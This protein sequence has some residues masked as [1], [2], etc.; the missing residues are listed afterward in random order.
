MSPYVHSDISP[1][2]DKVKLVEIYEK[3]FGKNKTDGFFIEAGAFNGWNWSPTSP[4]ALIGWSGVFVEPQPDLFEACCKRWESNKDKIHVIK[5]CVGN[6]DGICKLYLNGS[7]STTK[8][9]VMGI[10]N[11]LAL[12]REGWSGQLS[13][14]NFIESTMITLDLLINMFSVPS[15]FDILVID[16]EGAEKDVLDGLTLEEYKPKIMIIETH[17]KFDVK[18]LSAKASV[19]SRHLTKYD[20]KKVYANYVNSIFVH[21]EYWK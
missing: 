13:G 17:E 18:E 15:D 8:K 2:I 6:R 3:V 9:S 5:T 7:T 12:E 1:Q 14:D 21:K 11:K 19:I 20:Y 16:V 4:L 10:Y